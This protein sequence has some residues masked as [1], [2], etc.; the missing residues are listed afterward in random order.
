M[1]TMRIQNQKSSPRF[2]IS[3]LR[4]YANSA[5]IRDCDIDEMFEFLAEDK[6][7]VEYEKIKMLIDYVMGKAPV[8]DEDD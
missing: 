7:H 3:K 2:T 6:D 5:G 1:R 8:E 4:E